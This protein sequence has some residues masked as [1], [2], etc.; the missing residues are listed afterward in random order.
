VVG[1]ERANFFFESQIFRIEFRVCLRIFLWSRT[2][3][4]GGD[5]E[6]IDSTFRCDGLIGL[7]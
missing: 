1:A 5:T 4:L 6:R 3:G 2:A 7:H